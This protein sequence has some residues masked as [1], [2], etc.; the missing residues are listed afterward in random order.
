MID[1]NKVYIKQSEICKDG[2]GA[3]AKDKIK[4][5]DRVEIGLVRLLSDNSN[6]CFDGMNNPYVFTWSDDIP[7]YTWAIGSG[8]AT[9]YNTN[10]EENS[11]TIFKRYFKEMC[12][13]II[14]KRNIE[15][16]EEL[17]HTYKSLEWRTVFRVVRNLLNY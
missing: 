4:K 7:N 8:C 16:D 3:F 2:L 10:S 15:K 13:E 17:T 1:C 12:F 6:K 11:N 5:G 14:A 9:F